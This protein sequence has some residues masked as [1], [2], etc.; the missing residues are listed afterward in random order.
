MTRLDVLSE[1]VQEGRD[2]MSASEFARWLNFSGIIKLLE[3]NSTDGPHKVDGPL[4]RWKCEALIKDCN[5]QFVR[6][7]ESAELSKDN[8]ESLHAKLDRIAGHVSRLTVRV[9]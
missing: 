3:Q 7:S 6:S 2:V 9:G 5:A 4:V 1:R 8:V